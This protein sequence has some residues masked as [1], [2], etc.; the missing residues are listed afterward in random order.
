MKNYSDQEIIRLLD[1][2]P[3]LIQ[4]RITSIDTAREIVALGKTKGLHIDQIVKIAEL[5]RNMLLGIVSPQEFLQ[6]LIAVE[7]PDADARQIMTEI[8][9]KVFI[10][11]RV[12]MQKGGA[13]TDQPVR[14]AA[15]ATPQPRASAPVPNYAPPRSPTVTTPPRFA[16]RASEM[17]QPSVIIPANPSMPMRPQQQDYITKVSPKY[18]PPHQPAPRPPINVMPPRPAAPSQ[19]PTDTSRMLEDHEE[20][21]IDFRPRQSVSRITPPPPNLPGAILPPSR[22]TPPMPPPV[23]LTPR[24]PRPPMESYSSDPYRESFDE[25]TAE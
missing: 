3:Q 11:L 18:V 6:E 25:Q 5:N 14:P 4:A 20:A 19:K 23:P 24:P 15:P 21:H 8:N 13:N 1:R 2:A 17:S 22:P 9:Q 10:P 12:Q 16:P 7:I